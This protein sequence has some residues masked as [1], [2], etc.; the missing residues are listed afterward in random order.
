M[1][2]ECYF[3]TIKKQKIRFTLDTW[4]KLIDDLR[5]CGNPSK[6]SFRS[7]LNQMEFTDTLFMDIWSKNICQTLFVTETHSMNCPAA[8]W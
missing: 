8:T 6:H 4:E 5:V 1:K 2:L 3:S 7:K